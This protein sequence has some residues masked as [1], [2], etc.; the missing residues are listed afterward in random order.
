[1][2]YLKDNLK[3]TGIVK[4]LPEDN[5]SQVLSKL[6]S[7][8]DASFVFDNNEKFLGV[9]NPYYAMIHKTA[10]DGNTK[11]HKAIFHPPVLNINDVIERV[12]K[13][14]TESKIHYL[15]VFND[16]KEFKGIITAR[17]ILLYIS[18]LKNSQNPIS[19]M[20]HTQKGVVITI[21]INE[22]VSKAITL[23]KEY[24]TSK[25]VAVDDKGKLKGVLSHYDLI[26]FLIAPT[27]RT[28]SR[29]K[30][31]KSHFKDTPIKNFVKPAVLKMTSRD[32]IKDA[33]SQIL[34]REIGSVI[35]TDEEDRPTGIIT[36]KDFLNIL[37]DD[38]NKKN[39]IIANNTLDKAHKPVFDDFYEYLSKY[40]NTEIELSGAEFHYHKEKDGHLHKV[41]LHLTPVKGKIH[42]FTREGHDFSRLLQELKE[43]IR[44][45]R[46]KK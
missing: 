35:L 20:R 25:I 42:I 28:E 6:K 27:Q 11:A 40:V 15:P 33:I 41:Q 36:T 29:G 10:F 24:K 37:G 7:S 31:N 38:N 23:F 16:E 45:K 32:S 39:I 8:H 34:Q 14:M 13:M 30:G 21:N 19:T 3:K 18:K 22:P 43:I 9:V 2:Q 46:F 17:R 26:P 44:D 12:V 1:M 5:L 4:S